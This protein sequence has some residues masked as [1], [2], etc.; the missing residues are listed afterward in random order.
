MYYTVADYVRT[1]GVHPQTLRR[2]E[3]EKRPGLIAPV[4][5]AGNH[6]RYPIPTT[7]TLKVCYA[8]V[9]SHDQKEDLP[10]QV[11]RLKQHAGTDA[12]VLTD[13]GSGLNCRKPGLKKL[14]TLLLSGPVCELVLTY[15]ARAMLISSSIAVRKPTEMSPSS[16]MWL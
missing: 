3:R 15:K 13:I 6:R 11:E 14:M 7:G 8:R 1:L 2:W 9:S 16:R 12:V 5:T 4:R 10:R